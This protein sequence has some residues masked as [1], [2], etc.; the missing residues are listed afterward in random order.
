MKMEHE[1][2][3]TKARANLIMAHP[4]FGTLAL[5]MKLIK[6]EV[7]AV[8]HDKDGNPIPTMS[9]D[10]TAIYYHPDFPKD[11][12]VNQL[13]AVF[14]HEVLHTAFMHHTRQGMRD[15]EGWNAAGDYAINSILTNANFDLPKP[16][17][18][19]KKY[20]NMSAEEIYSLLEKSDGGGGGGR[21]ASMAP[22]GIVLPA[23][24]Q[25]NQTQDQANKQAES[26]M[27]VALAQA[28]HIAKQAGKLP[29]DLERLVEEV[30]EPVI[31][32]K[33]VLRR[34]MMESSRGDISWNYPNRR[35]AELGI[36][37]PSID[38][39]DPHMKDIVIAVDTSGSIGPKELSEFAAEINAIHEDLQPRR[40][41]VIYCD[42]DVNGEAII[43]E[44]EDQ[45]Y[46]EPRGGGGTD[47]RP[48]FR[49]V[50]QENFDP[51]CFVYLTDGYGAFP[52]EHEV[53][54][55]VMWAMTSDVD[56]PFGETL[57]ITPSNV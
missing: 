7:K 24:K 4:F 50:D 22:C 19:D 35:S 53:K 47:F 51:Q 55:P 23:P 29:A 44:P 16:N 20:D 33:N 8:T 38:E 57:R 49:L 41:I 14:A 52:E 21:G 1:L 46:L 2:K 11:K 18:Y 5:R 45:V 28:A 3:I 15:H 17:L 48:P 10:G 12:T 13:T 56:A 6:D 9:T 25:G 40:T 42:A 36:F 32:W 54:Y 30:L 26:E 34:F 31:P 39:D 37:L 27:K 43:F